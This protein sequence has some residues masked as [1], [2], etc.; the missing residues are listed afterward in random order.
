MGFILASG[1]SFTDP[2]FKSAIHPEYDTSYPKWPEILG[3]N[4]DK[5]VINLAKSGASNDKISNDVVRKLIK[6]FDII[7][8]VCVGWT[9]PERYTVWDHYNLNACNV[10]NTKKSFEN[11]QDNK[12]RDFYDWVWNDL[13][14]KNVSFN[15]NPLKAI[16][17]NFYK[18]VLLVQN[19]CE[20]LNI[21]LVHGFVCGNLEI[22]RFK[23]LEKHYEKELQYSE[24]EWVKV[25]S[26]PSEFYEI[27][28]SKFFGYPILKGLGGYTLYDELNDYRIS[29]QDAHPNK[30]GH[31]FIAEKYYETY[32]NSIS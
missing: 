8:L 24:R 20:L 30:E 21:D 6:D 13:L 14:D 5:K 4:L 7:D 17:D 15:N 29:K 19:I 9:Q 11:L 18:N 3:K 2:N 27:E 12:S 16:R 26:E 28:A 32:K 23:W 31:E 10:R 1:C 22:N 25:I